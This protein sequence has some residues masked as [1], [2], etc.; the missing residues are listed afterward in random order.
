[1]MHVHANYITVCTFYVLSLYMHMM[2]NFIEYHDVLLMH[3]Q[4]DA[5]LSFISMRLMSN[6]L[7]YV[8]IYLMCI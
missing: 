7:A 2:Q 5:H 6:I 1:M 4:P 3:V 8:V